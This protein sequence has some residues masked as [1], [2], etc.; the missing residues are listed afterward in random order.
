MR[1]LTTSPAFLGGLPLHP[2]IVH[3]AVVL[4]P[5]SALALLAV[6]FVPRWRAT[7]AWIPVFGLVAGTGAAIA[8]MVSGNQF[9]T[10][11]GL[12]VRHQ[13]LGFFLVVA[14]SLLTLVA[15]V[16]WILQR[17]TEEGQTENGATRALGWVGVL[18]TVPVLVLVVLT[19]HSGAEAAW[20]GIASGSAVDYPSDAEGQEEGSTS[21]AP[22][23]DP[24]E[25]ASEEESAPE[26]TG[27]EEAAAASFT[28][29]E[30]AEHANAESCWAVIGGNV[31]NLTDWIAQHPGGPAPIEHLC[32]TDATTVFDSQHATSPRPNEAL[33]TFKIGVLE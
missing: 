2:L 22:E 31:Y 13:R 15:L 26:G 19:G 18:L 24:A 7:Y 8:S 9:A 17:R 20:G 30:V 3:A 12:P 32:G 29:E 10:V 11:V 25:V 1:I 16:W 4:I 5:L 14:A 6:I 23:E 33:T 21:A 28:M 27:G